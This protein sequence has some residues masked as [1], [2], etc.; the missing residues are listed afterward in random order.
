ME[1]EKTVTATQWLGK[2]I[3]AT[4]NTHATT[5]ALLETV[6]PMWFVLYQILS[7]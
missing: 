6:F 3:P 5:E 1:P 2:H 4:R 7:M